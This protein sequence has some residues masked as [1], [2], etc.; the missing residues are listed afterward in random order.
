[1]VLVDDKWLSEVAA[2]PLRIPGFSSPPQPVGKRGDQMHVVGQG[3]LPE[4]SRFVVSEVDMQVRR[5][6][7]LLRHID[8]PVDLNGLLKRLCHDN[9]DLDI[10]RQELLAFL[11]VYD[12]LSLRQRHRK[13][14]VATEAS[15]PCVWRRCIRL[16]WLK[17][18]FSVGGNPRTSRRDFAVLIDNLNGNMTVCRSAQRRRDSEHHN[19]QDKSGW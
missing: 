10:H 15:V 13:T 2:G 1:M 5:V 7:A 11:D 17:Q 4:H 6:P 19:G 14:S 12:R 18:P 16:G 9:V 3:E 8:P